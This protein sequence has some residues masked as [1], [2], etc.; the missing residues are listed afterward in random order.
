MIGM[1]LEYN[2]NNWNF[3]GMPLEF[4]WNAV[5]MELTLG[6][7]RIAIHLLIVKSQSYTNSTRFCYIVR[8]YAARSTAGDAYIRVLFHHV[9]PAC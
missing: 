6:F 7:D 3:I 2:W 9:S 8:S 4:Y 5:G 1:P